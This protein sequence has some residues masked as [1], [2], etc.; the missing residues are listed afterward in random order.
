ML[1]HRVISTGF[2]YL[3]NGVWPDT[4]M[5]TAMDLPNPPGKAHTGTGTYSC[6]CANRGTHTGTHMCSE[7][8]VRGRNAT[9]HNVSQR[10]IESRGFGLAVCI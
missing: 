10:W 1:A 4:F 3:P 9:K 7:L 2:G 6:A 5:A 8:E